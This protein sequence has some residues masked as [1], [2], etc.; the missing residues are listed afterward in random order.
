MQVREY[1]VISNPVLHLDRRFLGYLDERPVG[2]RVQQ[3]DHHR[4]AVMEAHGILGH[5]GVLVARRQVTQGADGGLGDVLS[6]SG[7]EH[8]AHQ[9]FDASDLPGEEI[10]VKIR[11]KKQNPGCDYFGFQR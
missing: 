1:R 7:A 9:R 11:L 5:L 10:R 8:R 6:V 3:F 4:K 2:R